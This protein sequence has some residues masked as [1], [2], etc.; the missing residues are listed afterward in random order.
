MK[1]KEK[2]KYNIVYDKLFIK[3]EH[4]TVLNVICIFNNSVKPEI[5]D[6]VSTNISRICD[7]TLNPIRNIIENS[8]ISKIKSFKFKSSVLNSLLKT[9]L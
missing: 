7:D 9:G 4:Y 6:I 3:L 5:K 1:L 2:I 8:K